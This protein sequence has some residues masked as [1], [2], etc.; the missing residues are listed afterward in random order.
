MSNHI[1]PLILQ[2]LTAFA[3]RRR[4]LILLR[5]VCA[6]VAMGLATMMAVAL[7]D[8]FFVLE[9]WV[10]W[11]LSGVAY[12]AVIVVEWRACVR[13]L[14][15]SPGPRQVARLIEHAD[16][17]LREDLLSAV[18]LGETDSAFDSPQFR[19]LAQS[20]VASRLRDVDMSRLL[21]VQLVRRS[22]LVAGAVALVCGA[23]FFLT[24]SSFGTLLLRA[25]L[26]GA[27]L[28]RVSSVKINVVEPH[29]AELTVP[30]GDSVPL[31]VE[32]TG[33]RTATATLEIFSKTG[34]RE[35]VAMN[36]AADGRFSA[37]IQVGREDVEYRI[38]AHDAITRKFRLG[39]A[40]RPHVVQFG[41]TYRFPAYTQLAPKQI[42]EPTGDLAA[43]EGTEVDLRIETDQPVTVAELAVE[44]GKAAR[45]IPLRRTQDTVFTATVPLSASGV[46]RVRLVAQGTQ[47]ENKFSPEYELRA[48]P[49]LVPAVELETPKHDLIV[50]AN[51]IVELTGTAT[52]DLS[53]AR[54]E[55]HFR[56]NDGKWTVL[57]LPA[58]PGAKVAIEHRWDLFQQ[59]LE[60][61]DTIAVKLV[62]FDL[63][64]SKG[65][66]RPLQITLT[67]AGFET[68]RMD[69]I[70]AQRKLLASVGVLRGAADALEKRGR[71]TR[72]QF[73]RLPEGDAQRAP[74]AAGFAASFGDFSSAF[75]ETNTVLSAAL[76]TST[77]VH[78]S[79]DHVMLGRLLSR[80]DGGAVQPARDALAV[81]ATDAAQ[82]FARELVREA[83]E[84]AGRAAQRARVSEE[85]VRTLLSAE[86]IDLLN[87]NLQVVAR[88][89]DRIA[90][91]APGAGEDAAKWEPLISRLRVVLAE[92]RSVEELAKAA[93]EHATGGMG[94]RVRRI[95]GELEKQRTPAERQLADGKPG[96]GLAD[97]A[98]S[99]GKAANDM[100]R[101]ALE[102]R[103]DTAPQPPRAFG[104]M[105]QDVQATWMNF[106]KLRQETEPIL[107]SGQIP[108]PA[109][110]SL[111]AA[112]WAAKTQLFKAH[113]DWEE[114]RPDSD[115]YFV[116][117]VRSA[118]LALDVLRE[119]VL[120]TDDASGWDKAT[121]Q[122]V[123]LDLSFRVLE[124]GHD[125]LELHDGLVRLAGTERWEA[126]AV[127]ARTSNPR[128]WEWLEARLKALPDALG[129]L[130]LNTKEDE[131]ARNAVNAAQKVLR[132][133]QN[134]ASARA[135]NAE[136]KERAKPER[137]P[138]AVP[139]EV[140][141]LAALVKQALALLRP[142]MDEARKT[143]A[144]LTPKLQERM[145]QL[146]KEAEQ[147]KQQSSEQAEKASAK[148]PE[149]AQA[150][151]K[152]TLAAQE[153]LDQKI[154]ALK[155]AIRSDANKQDVLT[156]EG[157]ERARD[158]DDALAMLKE[159]PPR[160]EQA[161]SDAAQAERPSE[162]KAALQSAANEQDKLAKALNQ[163]AEHFDAAEKGTPAD[164]RTALRKAEEA[165]GVKE[166]LD[167]QYAHAEEVGKLAQASPQEM[168]KQLEAALPHNA[169]MR[170]ELSAVSESTLRAANEQLT[171]A[172][173]QEKQVAQQLAAGDAAQRF[174][175]EAQKAVD[176]AKQAAEAA[177]NAS[178]LATSSEKRGEAM[179]NA[180]LDFKADASAD[181]ADEAAQSADQAAAA[182]QQALNPG[183]QPQQ[184]AQAL[185]QAAQ[186][187]AEA[188][189]KATQ[190]V[191]DAKEAQTIAQQAADKGGP[192]QANSQQAKQEAVQA[193]QAAQ[194]A[195]QAA[196]TAHAAAQQASE[197]AKGVQPNAPNSPTLAQA[198]Q[199]QTPIAKATTDAGEGVMRA[200]RHE[201]RL[202]NTAPGEQLQKLGAEI[203]ETATNEIA[204]AQQ[205]LASAQMAEQAQAPVNAA[206]R[207]LSNELAQL[208]QTQS[209]PRQAQPASA[210]P[211]AQPAQNQPANAPPAASQ[212]QVANAQSPAASP[213]AANAQSPAASP[214]AANAQTAAGQPPPTPGAPPPAS[215]PQTAA[216]ARQ[217]G[218]DESAQAAAAQPGT[219]SP[220][221]PATA[222]TETPNEPGQPPGSEPPST[223]Q[224]LAAG[225]PAPLNAP[226]QEQVWMA[227]TL[228]A[229]D[230]ALHADPS[231]QQASQPPG[232]APQ[233]PGQG[234]GQ[235]SPSQGKD[236]LAQAKQAMNA[237]AQ[238]TA[239]SMR[240][241]R[242][243]KPTEQQAGEMAE[244][245]EEAMSK[246]GVKANAGALPR[247][248]LP[249]AATARNGDWGK[250]PKQVAEQLS[251]GQR[252]G[253]AGE[254]RNQV[255][256]Y[257]RVI[258]ERA[259]KQ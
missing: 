226:P 233:P 95:G 83:A 169:T 112:R 66:S 197:L 5:G 232:G 188:A 106:E 49:D 182:A 242:N 221:M 58:K 255:E 38:R 181:R 227:R 44:Q 251:Q 31:V 122:F 246:G 190:S 117:D 216:N 228:D 250:L 133:A 39:A 209:A 201:E 204:Q 18:E 174:K 8:R 229:L 211:R 11:T 42:A 239:A 7:I 202:Q 166:A 127:R 74:T 3:R 217:A 80:A 67:A 140:E 220:D 170:Q 139:R 234:Q 194:Q 248:A 19:E 102:L 193:E 120:A 54:V 128:D 198:A 136:M 189:Q 41:K 30:Q 75:A 135:I 130:Q 180:A 126:A 177:R 185:A 178:K 124:S 71:E 256:T 92:T 2:K 213:A 20:G 186:K 142:H 62:A 13:L 59:G 22:L 131:T 46:Y 191:G 161:L 257:Y 241:S 27:N 205:A 82:P 25:L 23:G 101:A 196:Q 79:G 119:T 60:A 249:N 150:E 32:L 47:F 24:G 225:Q 68:T 164:T 9:D 218:T 115:A 206:S 137:A 230:A 12:A 144:A 153:R 93:A 87:E 129:K 107:H 65:E 236:G 48:N 138:T 70:E 76:R 98:V 224:M 63:K 84:A 97:A 85:S 252:E 4:R 192:Q 114:A 222:Q 29:P 103:R 168:L 235:P 21:P 243:Q 210:N 167:A 171:Q 17:R 90:Q 118:T 175:Q 33:P 16:P 37:S 51:D 184:A 207:E 121:P 94:D 162:Q 64:G 10:R 173:A 55:Q 208:T 151:A 155:D 132:D 89:Q 199:G 111:A 35:R 109:R 149:E 123:S 240:S 254:Y 45:V 231:G 116:G 147:L 43:I 53:I 34:G 152:Q 247:G 253:V 125:I 26:P 104:F 160:A 73:D 108:A 212:Q 183:Q 110:V 88:E 146:A 113:G 237:A 214:A 77:P 179:G 50:P 163:L 69:F 141:T 81:V 157:R 145:A 203:Q 6:A 154:D 40:A 244:G 259:K 56:V 187:A 172:A 238:A 156:A 105:L 96:K 158:A 215:A 72:E 258:A 219:P 52:D 99:L 165:L 36:P 143:L 91:L 15:H 57:A 200:G 176:A 78:A 223:A 134:D 28:A 86:E 148:Q 61:G 245:G 159:P 195:L 14:L 1:D 100:R